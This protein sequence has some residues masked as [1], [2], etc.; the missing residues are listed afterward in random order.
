[1]H[2]GYFPR[3]S[4]TLF[5][6]EV[7]SRSEVPALPSQLFCSPVIWV[8]LTCSCSSS[9]PLFGPCP[10][11]HPFTGNGLTEEHRLNSKKV[12]VL[13]LARAWHVWFTTSLWHF[14]DTGG[15]SGR[16]GSSHIPYSLKRKVY[17]WQ[18]GTADAGL[19]KLFQLL[20]ADKV[21]PWGY[22]EL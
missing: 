19:R 16:A 22:R 11:A 18:W 21:V 7:S 4:T 17:D 1:M 15:L 5:S 6:P 12:S 9:L 14:L 2:R 8:I 10:R 13:G 20:L 3:Q